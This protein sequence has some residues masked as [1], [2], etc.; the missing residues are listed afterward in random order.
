LERFKVINDILGHALGDLLLRAVVHR[1]KRT[2]RPQDTVAR[3]GGDEFTII[4][5][6]L[7]RTME[8]IKIADRIINALAEPFAIQGHELYVTGTIGIAVFP[9]GGE[10]VV[11]LVRNSNA[12][13]YRAREKGSNYYLVY[14]P[15]MNAGASDRLAIEN[16]LRKALN[17]NEFIVHYQPQVDAKSGRIVCLEALVR[18]NH[19][20]RGLVPPG[21]F[22]GLAEETGLI[23]P[24]GEWV[25]RTACQATKAWRDAG[26]SSLRISVNMSAKQLRRRNLVK[27]ITEI[28][29]ETGLDPTALEIELTESILID[30]KKQS[31]QALNELKAMGVHLAIDDFGTGYSSFMYLKNYP[32]DE[33]KIDQ[34]FIRNLG[35]DGSDTAITQSIISMARSLRLTTVAEG[36]ETAE[37]FDILRQ[38]GC[39]IMQGYYFSAPLSPISVPTALEESM[40]RVET[41]WPR[42]R[43]M[44]A[45]VQ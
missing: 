39:D 15:L 22:I 45:V 24:I 3:W 25:M 31:M 1:L 10:D 27:S 36:V 37:Q 41:N 42:P 11:S 16:E 20:D 34:S 30:G 35:C 13:M 19:P 9:D 5:P 4:L 12:A 38:Q 6:D 40:K 21:D 26:F 14:T 8:A 28:L 29:Q 32:V 18:W 2:I 7:G 23:I 43:Q 44:A 17:R 33:L